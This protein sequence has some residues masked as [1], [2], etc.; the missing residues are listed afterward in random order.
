MIIQEAENKY[1]KEM[2]MNIWDNFN[3]STLKAKDTPEGL[4]IA[5]FEWEIVYNSFNRK[6][7]K[8]A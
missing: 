7:Y 5:D 3:F 2:A 4:D 8:F 1:G 6:V